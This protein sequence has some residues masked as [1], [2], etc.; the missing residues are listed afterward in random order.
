[1]TQAATGEVQAGGMVLAGQGFGPWRRRRKKQL[2]LV[3]LAFIRAVV[4]AERRAVISI[5]KRPNSARK[6]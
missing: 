3:E 2:A 6:S 5:K 1:M 4:V